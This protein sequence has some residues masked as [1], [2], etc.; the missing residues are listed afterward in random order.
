MRTCLQDKGPNVAAK[1]KKLCS[2]LKTIYIK[3]S[4]QKQTA[5]YIAC[6]GCVHLQLT[7]ATYSRDE[8]LYSMNTMTARWETSGRIVLV[9]SIQVNAFH[10][11]LT[12]F[13]RIE[14]LLS[15]KESPAF[16]LPIKDASMAN[17]R[18]KRLKLLP[19]CRLFHFV[20]TV[21]RACRQLA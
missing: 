13:R 19:A 11:S 8:Q 9:F 20:I 12:H 3:A 16:L 15:K 7:L 5:T 4:H 2:H 1:S 14:K 18:K 6:F 17:E 10:T 21:D